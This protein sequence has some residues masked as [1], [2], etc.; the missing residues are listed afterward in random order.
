MHRPDNFF[1]KNKSYPT[2]NILAN[3]S[4]AVV[5]FRNSGTTALSFKFIISIGFSQ[6]K[7]C[8]IS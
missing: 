5:W 6:V 7:D 3:V 4:K 8:L 2:S 1:V